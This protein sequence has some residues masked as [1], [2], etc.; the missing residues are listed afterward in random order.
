MPKIKL[1][2][3]VARR[4]I[5]DDEDGW[6]LIEKE[7]VEQRRWATLYT[8]VVQRLADGKFFRTSYDQ[9]S[10]ELQDEDPWEY[11]DPEFVEVAPEAKIKMVYNPVLDT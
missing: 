6:K 8:V 3:V 7:I 11:C 1:D 2:K 9:G 10:T 5:V 4:I